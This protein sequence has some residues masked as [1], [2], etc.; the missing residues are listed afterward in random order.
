MKMKNSLKTALFLGG[1][2]F[3][4]QSYADVLMQ[5]QRT[6][7]A[8]DLN[9]NQERIIFVD[10]N[11]KIGYPPSLSSKLRI[12]NAGG[13]LYLKPTQAFPETRLQLQ[14]MQNGEIILLDVA[15]NEHKDKLEPIKL[16]YEPKSNMDEISG[17]E[18]HSQDK[19]PLAD[20]VQPKLTLPAPAAL[21]RYA[22][23]SLYAPLRTVEPLDGVQSVHHRLPNHITTL[24]PGLPV[25]TTPLAAWQL[26]DYVVTAVK[27][28]NQSYEMIK[29]DPRYIQGRFYA[30]TY[31]HNW[32]GG[33]GSAE[34]TTTVYLVSI[35]SADKA[36]IPEPKRVIKKI[37]K[38][39]HQG[40][41]K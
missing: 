1:I 16:I 20:I 8:I 35:G 4:Q 30:A 36:M 25:K 19:N 31:Q 40:G 7:L 11:V 3:F 9:V 24:L 29:L 10:R 33:R 34:D 2:A 26:G 15:A 41:K 13:T 17:D 23:Q 12:Q 5:W 32:L 21:T 22:A 6:P 38:N 39:Q 37:S 14:D 18:E 28:K 27:I